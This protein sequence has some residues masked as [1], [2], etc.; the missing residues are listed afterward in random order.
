MPLRKRLNIRRLILPIVVVAALI[1][2]AIVYAATSGMLGIN[3][4]VER[5]SIQCKLNIEAATNE[6]PSSTTLYQSDST[7]HATVDAY[8]RETLSFSTNLE[9]GVPKYVTFQVINVGGCWQELDTMSIV[10]S[11]SNGINVTWPSGLN[12]M[13]LGPTDS[14]GTQTITIEWASNSGATSTEYM[15]ATIEYTQVSGP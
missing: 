1:V 6:D 8:T 15:S 11:P 13:I 5:G 7:I 3:G 12:G 9:Y 4:S 10:T 2:S 14:S